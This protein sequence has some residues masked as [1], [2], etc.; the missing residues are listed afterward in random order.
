MTTT[1]GETRALRRRFVKLTGAG[2]RLAVAGPL[3]W[4]G[5]ATTN[6]FTGPAVSYINEYLCA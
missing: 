3:V 1:V 5:S 4:P 6:P 2:A